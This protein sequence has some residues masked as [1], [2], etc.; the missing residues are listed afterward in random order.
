MTSLNRSIVVNRPHNVR[1]HNRKNNENNFCYIILSYY[2]FTSLIFILLNINIYIIL[3]ING[4][5]F[6]ICLW[7]SSCHKDNSNN[8][9]NYGIPLAYSE[10]IIIQ[11]INNPEIEYTTAYQIN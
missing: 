8:E 6:L 2:C 5:T 9:I 7:C 4:G 1:Y 11:Y 3:L 10:P